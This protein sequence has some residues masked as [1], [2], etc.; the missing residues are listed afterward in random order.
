MKIIRRLVALLLSL[1]VVGLFYVMTLLMEN[2]DSKRSDDFVVEASITPL[3]PQPPLFSADASE[4]ATA[5][6]LAF[7]L[8]EGL[9]QGQVEDGNW[10]GYQTRVLRLAGTA[11]QVQGIRPAS[12]ATAV[13]PKGLT[14]LAS[15]KALLG[16]AL[17]EAAYQGGLLYSLATPEA[18][19]LIQPLNG[20]APGSFVWMEPGQ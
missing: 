16:H 15:E 8:P 12:A 18:V 3:R 19:F 2:E 4:L 1:M 10:H 7:P 5:F 14:F 9:S 13:L 6:G 11:A 17:L 20:D